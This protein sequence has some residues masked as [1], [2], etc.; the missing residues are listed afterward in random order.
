MGHVSDD[1]IDEGKSI[2]LHLSVLNKII[3]PGLQ[4]ALAS[5]R[6]HPQKVKFKY[7]TVFS[8]MKGCN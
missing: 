2:T 4:K 7:F 6:Y 3:Q 1:R 5:V 8:Q